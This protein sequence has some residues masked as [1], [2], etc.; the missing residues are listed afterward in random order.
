MIYRPVYDTNTLISAYLSPNGTTARAVDLSRRSDVEA[1]ACNELL[2]EYREK[3][4]GKFRLSAEEAD[5]LLGRWRALVNV[6][7]IQ[8]ETGFSSDPDDDMVLECAFVGG[9]TH[10]VTGD[11]K[12]LLPL[13]RFKGIPI[14]TPADFLKLVEDSDD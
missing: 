7:E 8:G 6:A 11:K 10:I 3:L 12:H 2:N 4:T 13:G 14:I 1:I 5:G 9:A